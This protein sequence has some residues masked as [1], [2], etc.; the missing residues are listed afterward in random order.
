VL[1]RSAMGRCK[2]MTMLKKARVFL[3]ELLAIFHGTFTDI[4][5]NAGRINHFATTCIA[6]AESR[7]RSRGGG[8]YLSAR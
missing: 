4:I 8:G 7:R 6:P 1:D 3:R 2:K 5:W